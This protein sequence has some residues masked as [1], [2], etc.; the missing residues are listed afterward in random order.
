MEHQV[1]ETDHQLNP[2]NIKW[3]IE[4]SRIKH[5]MATRLIGRIKCS[6]VLTLGDILSSLEKF[7]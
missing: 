7:S 6:Q 3:N 2:K 1:Q 5:L 4:D